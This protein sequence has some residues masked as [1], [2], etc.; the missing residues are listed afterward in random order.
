MRLFK[1]VVCFA[2]EKSKIIPEEIMKRRIYP[3]LAMILV[4]LTAAALMT[5]K[6]ILFYDEESLSELSGQYYRTVE[7]VYPRG[8]IT[9]RNGI[10]FNSSVSDESENIRTYPDEYPSAAAQ[11]VGKTSTLPSDSTSG[12]KTGANGINEIYDG[13]L[14]GGS[15]IRVS[16]LCDAEG[17][18]VRDAGYTVTGEHLNEGCDITLTIDY[19]LQKETEDIIA[20]FAGKNGYDNIAVTITDC[21]SGEIMVMA[22][23]GSEMN[24]NVLT[25][26]P[27]SVMKIISAASALE[28]G[29]IKEDDIFLCTGSFPVGDRMRYCCGGAVHGKMKMNEAFAVSCNQWAYEINKSLCTHDGASYTSKVLSLAKKWGFCEYGKEEHIFPLEYPGYYS[30][31]P[32]KLYNEM[33]IFNCALGQGKIQASVYLINRL[34]SAIASS[35]KIPEPYIIS[36]IT[37][38]A[39]NVLQSGGDEVFDLGLKEETVTSLKKFMRTTCILGSAKDISIPS[40]AGKTGTAEGIPGEDCLCWFTG[41]FPVSDKNY[42]MTVF[43]QNGSSAPESAVPLWDIIAQNV[44][45]F[46]G[47]NEKK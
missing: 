30:F 5:G 26:P 34:T 37:D 27:G 7:Y 42:A 28:E 14:C 41:Y 10:S 25:Y 36:K 44:L 29:I 20:G 39:G 40:A 24:M 4:L 11:V 47:V 6:R 17:N 21:Y 43:V 19:I 23:Y 33:D 45:S 3:A 1:I 2:D 15:A 32:Q 22:T 31:V 16:G 13:L 12:G 38:A 18:I 46:Y 8:N 9:D 35:G